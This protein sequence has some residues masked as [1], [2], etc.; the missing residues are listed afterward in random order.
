MF[1][2]FTQNNSGLHSHRTRGMGNGMHV[3]CFAPKQILTK[4]NVYTSFYFARLP[5][6]AIEDTDKVLW[7]N[8]LGGFKGHSNDEKVLKQ[9]WIDG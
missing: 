1:P 4:T 8:C 9:L 6:T 5:I 3:D 7:D 2:R